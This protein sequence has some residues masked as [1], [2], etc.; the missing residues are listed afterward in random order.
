MQTLTIIKET[1]NQQPTISAREL[2]KKLGVGKFFAN[3]IKDRIEEY[4][5]I[6]NTDYVCLPNLASKNQSVDSP[7]LAN[8]KKGRGGHN[9]IEYYLTLE[10]AKELAMVERTPLGKQYRCYLIE[11]EKQYRKLH[12]IGRYGNYY[13]NNCPIR[14]TIPLGSS[15]R[16]SALCDLA[17]ACKISAYRVS[18]IKQAAASKHALVGARGTLYCLSDTQMRFHLPNAIENNQL[19]IT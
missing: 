4:D 11:V 13:I 2:H 14:F 9:I 15:E 10:M 19:A 17:K 16:F 1:G 12:G 8:Q 18:K 6:E 7:N 5:F 3:W